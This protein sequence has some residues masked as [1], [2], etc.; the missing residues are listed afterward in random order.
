VREACGDRSPLI[1]QQNLFDI[2]M[3]FGDVVGEDEAREKL[4]ET[5]K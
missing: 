5:W 2:D 1:Q 4:A 3:G